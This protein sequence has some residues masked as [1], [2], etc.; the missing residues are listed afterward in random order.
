LLQAAL[1]GADAVDKWIAQFTLELRTATFLSGV[2]RVRDLATR[3][4][5]VTGETR[6]WIDQLG[7]A[8]RRRASRRRGAAK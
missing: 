1:E 5:V 2:T 6:D 7:Y 4:P 8:Q 3:P